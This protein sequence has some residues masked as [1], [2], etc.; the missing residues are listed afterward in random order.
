MVIIL[1]DDASRKFYRHSDGYPHLAGTQLLNIVTKH[2]FDYDL[3]CNAISGDTENY[4]QMDTAPLD[5][6][7]EYTIDCSSKRVFCEDKFNHE[8][9][10]EVDICC[11]NSEFGIDSNPKHN[12]ISDN[13]PDTSDYN[14]MD[15]NEFADF[16]ELTPEEIAAIEAELFGNDGD[17]SG[18]EWHP[19]FPVDMENPAELT[20]EQIMRGDKIFDA[21]SAFL[22]SHPDDRDIPMLCITQEWEI[23][24]DYGGHRCDSDY[25]DSVSCVMCC[26]DEGWFA[27]RDYIRQC[28]PYLE[29]ELKQS[30]DFCMEMYGEIPSHKELHNNRVSNLQLEIQSVAYMI[31]DS[32]AQDSAVVAVDT[33]TQEVYAWPTEAGLET[34]GGIIHF[35]SI[36][37]LS[38]KGAD[39]SFEISIDKIEAIVK[40]LSAPI[41]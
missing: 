29:K 21:I 16:D 27:D 14:I 2:N 35:F 24:I 8:Y 33:I 31:L 5:I 36:A 20:A 28:V 18:Y 30:A 4:K 26:D 11:Y 10:D 17:A 40:K 39:G 15:D 25:V 22:D 1:K 37:D 41:S 13:E 38:E 23:S 6:E 7:F 19:R 3:I 12:S 34:Y 32:G 9:L